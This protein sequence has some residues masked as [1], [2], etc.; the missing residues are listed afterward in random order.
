MKDVYMKSTHIFEPIMLY[1][2]VSFGSIVSLKG[3]VTFLLPVV[4]YL[5]QIWILQVKKHYNSS[6]K[7]YFKDLI[8]SIWLK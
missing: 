7:M 2:S 5:M 1:M 4:F 8:K 6:W 3:V